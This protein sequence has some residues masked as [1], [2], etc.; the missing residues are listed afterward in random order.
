MAADSRLTVEE[1][2]LQAL[3]LDEA[4]RAEYLAQAC[5]DASTRREVESLLAGATFADEL[6]ESP[7]ALLQPVAV[8][9]TVAPGPGSEIGPYQLLEKLGEGGMGVV[10]RARQEKPVRREV[11][12]KIIRPGWDTGL[13][14]ARFAAERQALALMEHVNIA[15]V[16]DAGT[17]VG[18]RSYFVME[19]VQGKPITAYCDEAGLS[20]RQRVELMIPVCQ[21]IRHAHQKG[22]IHR[23]IKPSNILV[24][25]DGDAAIPKV[26]DF[27]IAKA[28][29]QPLHDGAT[30]TR[31]F[32]IVGTFAYMSPEQAEPGARDIDVR[33]DVYSLGAVLYEV[34]SGAPPLGAL[35]LRGSSYTAILKRIQE[36]APPP[37]SARAGGESAAQL[38]GECDWIALKALEKDRERRY[39]SAGALAADLRR[40]LAGEPVEAGP[41]SKLYRARKFAGRHRWTLGAAAAFVLVLISAVVW[42][43][44]ALRQQARLNAQ[45]AALREVVRKL[46]VERPQQLAEVPGR[47]GLRNQLIRDAESALAVLSKDTSNDAGLALDLARAYH[48]IG[49]AK[50]A[51]NTE[52]SEGDTQ[53]AIMYL[54]KS[55]AL[56]EKVVSRQPSDA[57]I[58]S[59]RFR[60]WTTLLFTQRYAGQTR[61]AEE[62]AHAIL[63]S[64]S[65]LPPNVH[66]SQSRLVKAQVTRELGILRWD[67]GRTRESYAL[68]KQALADFEATDMSVTTN[69]RSIIM[70]SGDAATAGWEPLGLVPEVLAGFRRAA[71]LAGKCEG[72]SCKY[73]YQTALFNWGRAQFL[74]GDRREGLT[75]LRRSVEIAETNAAADPTD[76]TLRESA[77]FAR[78]ALIEVLILPGPYMSLAEAIRLARKNERGLNQKDNAQRQLAVANR[79]VFASALSTA[80]QFGDAER[81]L[82]GL[83]SQDVQVRWSIWM[84]RGRALEGL[85]RWEQAG[86]ARRQALSL[87][88]QAPGDGLSPPLM[89]AIS[90]RDLARSVIR[91]QQVSTHD[92][93]EVAGLLDTCCG[94]GPEHPH[95][96]GPLLLVP[97]QP[98]EILTLR[99]ALKRMDSQQSPDVPGGSA[100]GVG[101][102]RRTR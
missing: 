68:M 53:T 47:T 64:V 31:A 30:F 97:P 5:G 55:V 32:Y 7:A 35:S 36:E 1:I 20:V 72:Q 102:G 90:V 15:R 9:E 88:L 91:N 24:A 33:A 13:V 21:A 71:E 54:A 8:E 44:I 39:E 29:E 18:E 56:F 3:E 66:A 34:L 92:R 85:G 16:L 19:L 38:R 62:T 86:E 94:P 48:S 4:G 10:Y 25:R 6:L 40:Y 95:R 23:D 17:T 89:R 99:G 78:R 67:A 83:D 77:A 98:R 28:T 2:C 51:Y 76:T 46:L 87:A 22:I 14:A 100:P 80:G 79:I 82:S 73:Y 26:I 65:Q 37:P 61:E 101:N 45:A 43:S 41:P 58:Q 84:E 27:G 96:V 63:R 60:A 50:G 52:G 57:G 42:M 11:A 69:F 70:Q 59:A 74:T 75:K 49:Q 81:E 93:A 12:L